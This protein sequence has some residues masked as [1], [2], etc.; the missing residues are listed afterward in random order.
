M[1]PLVMTQHLAGVLEKSKML[2]DVKYA[3][4]RT[5][6]WFER[7]MKRFICTIDEFERTIDV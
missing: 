5:E 6:K 4:S 2:S 7:A 3:A 1:F